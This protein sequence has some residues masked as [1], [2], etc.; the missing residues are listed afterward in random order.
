MADRIHNDF[1]T[2]ANVG[3]ASEWVVTFPTRH[4]Y[5]DVPGA[6]AI[7][8][9]TSVFSGGIGAGVEAG[10]LADIGIDAWNRQGLKLDCI[11]PHDYR[12][13][14]IGVPSPQPPLALS[15][16]SNAINFKLRMAAAAGAQR[17]TRRAV[18]LFRC[19]ASSSQRVDHARF[20][21]MAWCTGRNQTDAAGEDQVWP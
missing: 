9:F 1:V 18:Q 11:P 13:C 2:G 16:S 5:A 7:P 10:A 6:T 21:V 12:G 20:P 4:F 3:G 14:I 8:P 15:W 17:H 19:G